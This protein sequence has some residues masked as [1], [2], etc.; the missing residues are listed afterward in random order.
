MVVYLE[1]DRFATASPPSEGDRH[2][3][4]LE[5]ELTLLDRRDGQAVWRSG[6]VEVVDVSRNVR[7]DFYTVQLIRLPATLTTGR[8]T[9]KARVTDTH[10]GTVDEVNLPI[11]LVT[12][13]AVAGI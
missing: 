4:R 7:R 5:Q 3:V 10:G 6:E 12:A 11:E 8:Y 2:E 9:L 1:I 13:E